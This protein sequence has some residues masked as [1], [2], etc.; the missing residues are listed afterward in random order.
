MLMFCLQERFSNQDCSET[1][2]SPYDS[3]LAN[4]P[5]NRVLGAFPL[6]AHAEMGNIREALENRGLGILLPSPRGIAK[7]L[8]LVPTP[9]KHKKD[10]F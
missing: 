9:K 2:T 1:R 6:F 5:E 8:K 7:N 10:D 4:T 3:G